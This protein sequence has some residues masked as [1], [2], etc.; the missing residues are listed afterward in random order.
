M[1]FKKLGQL[2]GVI[3][4]FILYKRKLFQ[5]GYRKATLTK[6]HCAQSM[7]ELSKNILIVSFTL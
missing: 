1:D 2:V 3:I 7:F 6:S 5:I 4:T